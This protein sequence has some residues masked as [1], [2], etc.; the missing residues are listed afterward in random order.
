MSSVLFLFEFM[1]WHLFLNRTLTWLSVVV[2]VCCCC[3][4]GCGCCCCCCCCRCRCLC[5]CRRHRRRQFLLF[6]LLLL[7]HLQRQRGSWTSKSITTIG[8]LKGDTRECWPIDTIQLPSY[9]VLGVTSS[10]CKPAHLTT[11]SL[12]SLTMVQAQAKRNLAEVVF[13]QLVKVVD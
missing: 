6:L 10:N 13:D 1:F 12:Q 7:L 5:S 2:S 4:C 11:S 9:L 3:G 8:C